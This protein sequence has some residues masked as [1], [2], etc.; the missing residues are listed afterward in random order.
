LSAADTVKIGALE[1]GDTGAWIGMPAG[2]T[3][4]YIKFT[5]TKGT[6]INAPVSAPQNG[7][8]TI[9]LTIA[10]DDLTDTSV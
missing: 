5:S 1:E 3:A 10:L 6:I 2:N 7:V 9:D 8:V 4:S